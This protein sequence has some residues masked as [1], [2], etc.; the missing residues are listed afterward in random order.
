MP[1]TTL[2]RDKI[3]LRRKGATMSICGIHAQRIRV[4]LRAHGA[5]LPTTATNVRPSGNTMVPQ[6]FVNSDAAPP[7]TLPMP[8][9]GRRMQ[10]MWPAHQC[11]QLGAGHHD[12]R[13]RK[14][15]QE[16]LS[17]QSKRGLTCKVN[18]HNSARTFGT[19]SP[20]YLV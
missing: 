9:A 2:P 3:G 11:L 19:C 17:M 16:P 14:Q 7:P 6:P 18:S 15:A 4:M 20:T 1:A 10:G 5:A 12:L 8:H 13:H